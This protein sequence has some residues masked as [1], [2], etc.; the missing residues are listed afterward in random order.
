MQALGCLRDAEVEQA[1]DPVDAHEDVGRRDV[2]VDDAERLAAL[3]GR[4]VRGVEALED[5]DQDGDGDERRHAL[6]HA[7]EC[8]Q[9]AVQGLPLHVLHDEEQ[10]ARLGDDIERLHH[11]RVVDAGRHPSFVEEHLDELRLLG[12]LRM[13]LLDGDD[14]RESDRP[15]QLAEEDAA[16]APCRELVVDGVPAHCAH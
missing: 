7:P 1:S 6:F 4:L 2:A 14:A 3:A 10:D 16:H 12:E 11:V 9:E 8:A 5:A 13:E 15:D